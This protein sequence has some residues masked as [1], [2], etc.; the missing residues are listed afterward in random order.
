MRPCPRNTEVMPVD[1]VGRR[2]QG[3]RQCPWGVKQFTSGRP[4]P[5]TGVLT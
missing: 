5:A 4:S 2:T 1:S 3:V